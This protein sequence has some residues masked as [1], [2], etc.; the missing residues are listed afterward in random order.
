MP[1]SA[2]APAA[3][4]VSGDYRDRAARECQGRA[5]DACERDLDV[6]K[7]MDPASESLTEVKAMHREI[8]RWKHASDAK[9]E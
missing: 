9:P 7:N 3:P 5:F 8:D 4:P 2:S 1:P 6:A